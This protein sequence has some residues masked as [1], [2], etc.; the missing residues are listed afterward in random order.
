[1][2]S[3]ECDG[4]NAQDQAMKQ[5]STISPPLSEVIAPKFELAPPPS[6]ALPEVI[7]ANVIP[8]EPDDPAKKPR[9]FFELLTP[10]ECREFEIP[11][12]H[13][14]CGDFHFTRGDITVLAG[15]PGC[16]KSRLAVALAVAGAT[17]AEWMGHEVHASFRTLILQAEN[18]IARLKSEFSDIEA[19]RVD[20]DEFVRVT[21][22]PPYGLDF[23][24]REFRDYLREAIEY[25]EAGVL[26][27]DPW[28]RVV[29]DDK[30]TDYRAAIDAINEALP[31][32]P[33]KKP[34]VVIVTHLRK[35][36]SGERRKRGR[37]LLAELSGSHFMASAPRCVF[38]L[39]PA[40]ADTDDDR[41]VL[42]CAK[43]NNGELGTASAWHRRN[44]LFQ[45][46]EDFDWEDYWNPGAGGSA[47]AKVTLEDLAAIFEDGER[48]LKK[49]EAVDLLR[50]QTGLG[51]TVCYDAL[52]LQ[53]GEF[54]DYLEEAEGVLRFKI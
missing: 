49:K 6:T 12:D 35:Q 17:E 51:R 26:V 1:V 9:Q 47:R 25:F 48:T 8:F 44:G 3:R 54:S 20:L 33:A 11:R 38:I 15:V 22:P 13:I 53:G 29:E 41:V 18:G 39:E 36:V 52:K 14:L 45:L 2:T 40:T 32:D 43:N 27:I 42:T 7:A 24:A 28:N 19:G 30:Q 34:A 50:K 16:G 31:T 5:S 46:C 37:D 10:S 21:P 4:I 23:A